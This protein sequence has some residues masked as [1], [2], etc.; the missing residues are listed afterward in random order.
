ML[1]VFKSWILRQYLFSRG[2]PTTMERP[3]VLEPLTLSTRGHHN[4]ARTG[5]N[6][7][8]ELNPVESRELQM[9]T[10]P[11]SHGGYRY[12]SKPNEHAVG[13]IPA[14]AAYGLVSSEDVELPITE[15]KSSSISDPNALS[16]DLSMPAASQ[17]P[18]L[19][20]LYVDSVA[21]TNEAVMPLQPDTMQPKARADDLARQ[22]RWAT[23]KILAQPERAAR[24][25]RQMID[26]RRIT[27]LA[28]DM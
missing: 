25:Y 28:L 4:L 9:S 19:S 22:L 17:S 15:K 1:E 8:S 21:T 7:V 6:K 5:E 10:S 20:P 16:N 13:S 26:E 24:V 27:Q 3:V 14:E 12:I 18:D 11:Q 2:Y 23:A